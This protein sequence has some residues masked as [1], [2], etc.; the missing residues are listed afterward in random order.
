MKILSVNQ[1]EKLNVCC[2]SEEANFS[3]FFENRKSKLKIAEK[4]AENELKQQINGAA[5]QCL[6]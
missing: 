4:K 5:G 2:N 6:P 3:R 1:G